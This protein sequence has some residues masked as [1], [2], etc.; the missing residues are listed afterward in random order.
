MIKIEDFF[1]E[2]TPYG[3]ES[4]EFYKSNK[5]RTLKTLN[6]FKKWKYLANRVIRVLGEIEAESK[7]GLYIEGMGYFYRE[8][9]KEIRETRQSLFRDPKVA[10]Y[11]AKRFLPDQ[12]LEDLSFSNNTKKSEVEYEADMSLVRVKRDVYDALRALQV[13]RAKKGRKEY[14][15]I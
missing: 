1:K 4:Y 12:G 14:I 7:N 15:N 9:I 6:E 3:R 10:K 2:V 11:Y 13:T 5:N 8:P